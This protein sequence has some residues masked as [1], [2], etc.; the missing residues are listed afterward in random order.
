MKL[1]LKAYYNNNLVFS[2]VYS[3]STFL[4]KK[5]HYYTSFKGQ[6]INRT[7]EILKS[8][9]IGEVFEKINVTK[10]IKEDIIERI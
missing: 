7:I 6:E 4:K 3:K 5:Y 9:D 8:D 1:Q 2:K 10:F